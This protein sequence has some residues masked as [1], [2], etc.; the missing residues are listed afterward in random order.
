MLDPW[1][2]AETTTATN[3]DLTLTAVTGYPTVSDAFALNEP[4]LYTIL[5]STGKPIEIGMGYLSASTTWVRHLIYATFSSGVYTDSGATAVTL[6]AGTKQV[7]I[8]PDGRNIMLNPP[9]P[10][11]SATANNKLLAPLNLGNY[12]ANTAGAFATQTDRIHYYPVYFGQK[13]TIDAFAFRLGTAGTSIDV[14]LYSTGSDGKPRARLASVVSQ[15]IATA[16]WKYFTV[17]SFQLK[18]GW[19]WIA[20]NVNNIAAAFRTAEISWPTL[21]F[22]TTEQYP[23][24]CCVENATFGTLPATAAPGDPRQDLAAVFTV[25]P[26]FLRWT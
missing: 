22:D 4:A 2:Y 14:G 19:Y 13:A 24:T 1:I 26:I 17:T 6:A 25:P 20:L 10:V 23:L 7:R 11:A 15:S 18:P 9:V 21:G 3:T 5:D 12:S 8:T 16:G